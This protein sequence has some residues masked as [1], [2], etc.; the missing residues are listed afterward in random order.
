MQVRVITED[1]ISGKEVADMEVTDNMPRN[2]IVK[3]FLEPRIPDFQQPWVPEAKQG[4]TCTGFV[5]LMEIP[6]AP[7]PPKPKRRR[8]RQSASDEPDDEFVLETRV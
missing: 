2:G 6:V 3:I 7:G 8:T 1:P 4:G 5:I